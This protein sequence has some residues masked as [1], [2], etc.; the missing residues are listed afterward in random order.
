MSQLPFERAGAVPDD[1]PETPR[2]PPPPVIPVSVLV[3]QARALIERNLGLTW[4]SGEISNFTRA[5]S[6]HCYFNLKDAQAQ[7]RCVMF[8]LKAQHVPF[9]LRDGVSVEVRAT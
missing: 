6:G 8:R 4:V 9:A 1:A 5:S 7:V 3:S 2:P